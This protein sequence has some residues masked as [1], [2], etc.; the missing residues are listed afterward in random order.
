MIRTKCI[1]Q[2]SVTLIIFQPFCYEDI[3]LL[4]DFIGCEVSDVPLSSA[5]LALSS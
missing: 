5:E 3:P 1:L 4:I 2:P